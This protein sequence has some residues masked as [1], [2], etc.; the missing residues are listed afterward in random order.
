MRNLFFSYWGKTRPKDGEFPAFH[1]LVYHNLDVT[2]VVSVW[3]DASPSIRRAFAQAV[4]LP[5]SQAKA[6][7]LFFIAL[8]DLGKF[9]LRFQ[10]KAKDAFHQLYGS[11]Q[12]GLS[13][14]QWLDYDQTCCSKAVSMCCW[15]MTRRLSIMSSQHS[16]N[17]H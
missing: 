5:E 17:E 11:L 13:E 16:R 1:L 7:V 14:N 10:L 4:G 3:W 12:H 8:H 15:R 9:D 2:A 6:W